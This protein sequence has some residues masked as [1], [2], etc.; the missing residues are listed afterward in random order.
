MTRRL[1]VGCGYV[2]RR[3]ARTWRDAGDTVFAMTR[4]PARAEEF[5][6]LGWQPVVAD[7]TEPASLGSLPRVDLV[8]HAVGY[9]RSSGPSQRDVYVDGLRSVLEALPMPMPRV[10]HVSSTSVY[11]QSD[12]SIVDETSP[13]EPTSES[14]RICLDAE[15][16]VR[17]SCAERGTI[18]RLA[19][20]YGP[21][22]LLRRVQ[23]LRSGEPIAGNP[24]AWL[25]LVHVDDAAGSIVRLAEDE[26]ASGH[27]Y[28][29]CDDVP[30]R[31]R[32]YFGQLAELV[33]AKPPTFDSSTPAR[34]GAGGLNKRCS[35]LRLRNELQLE[36]RFPSIEHGLPDAWARSSPAAR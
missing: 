4:S 9:D 18:V 16:L 6:A 8:L 35:N 3:V 26:R 30:V 13:T 2:G 23:G 10:V 7:V 29:V 25:N 14:G 28:L 5:R 24:D 31:R 21:D 15:Q 27:T 22:R 12:G 20:I 33:G 32:D 11:G 19:G 36:L 34:H 1:I 17:Q